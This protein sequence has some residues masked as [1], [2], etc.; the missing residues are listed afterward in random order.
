MTGSKSLK[1][2]LIVA[3]LTEWNA[4]RYIL[5]NIG[6]GNGRSTHET[7]ESSRNWKGILV[8]IKV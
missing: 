4:A 7:F 5:V 2:I 8:S 6:E 1:V 3:A